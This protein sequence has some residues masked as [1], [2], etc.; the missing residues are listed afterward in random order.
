MEETDLEEASLRGADL[1]DATLRCAKLSR[2]DLR[3][4]K[5]TEP[6]GILR[7]DLEQTLIDRLFPVT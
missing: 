6:H 5:L 1:T 7:K 4:A 3:G 2:A